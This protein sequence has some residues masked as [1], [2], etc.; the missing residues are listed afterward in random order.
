MSIRNTKAS[1]QKINVAP[2]DSIELPHHFNS[3]LKA[4]TKSKREKKFHQRKFKSGK[5]NFKK[6]QIYDMKK[7]IQINSG[8]VF[9]DWAI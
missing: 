6:C 8:K 7:E 4:A 5:C 9:H 1:N 3:F 2:I